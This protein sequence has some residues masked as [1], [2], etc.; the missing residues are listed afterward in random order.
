MKH[1]WIRRTE[2]KQVEVERVKGLRR[3]DVEIVSLTNDPY[4]YTYLTFV[5]CSDPR[6]VNAIYQYLAG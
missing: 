3:A 1:Q 4:D 6:L 2:L 5:P